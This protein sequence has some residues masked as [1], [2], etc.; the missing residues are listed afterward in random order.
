MKILNYKYP[1]SLV[2][3]FCTETT[4]TSTQRQNQVHYGY[5]C[6]KERPKETDIL[7]RKT[8]NYGYPYS[9]MGLFILVFYFVSPAGK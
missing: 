3:K 1:Y 5:P 8:I 2:A 4:D 9:I 7:V 6:H